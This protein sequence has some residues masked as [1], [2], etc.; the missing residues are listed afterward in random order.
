MY[1]VLSEYIELH[2]YAFNIHY[3]VGYI[4]KNMH[5]I[6]LKNYTLYFIKNYISSHFITK[7][8]YIITL[9]LHFIKKLYIKI[10]KILKNRFLVIKSVLLLIIVRTIIQKEKK[11]KM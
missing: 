2:T 1:N 7:K 9:L 5:Y 3:Y 11:V 4:K 10:I 6:L 8:L